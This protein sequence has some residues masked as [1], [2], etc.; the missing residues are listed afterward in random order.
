MCL[1]TCWG[2]SANTMPLPSVTALNNGEYQFPLHSAAEASRVKWGKFSVIKKYIPNIIAFS[3]VGESV[4]IIELQDRFIFFSVRHIIWSALPPFVR[5]L[6]GF[7]R[8]CSQVIISINL[9]LT[10]EQSLATLEP[11]S[12]PAGH[13]TN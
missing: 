2:L 1:S 7:L 10:K 3:E 13:Y 6:C 8:L 5:E 9:T 4:W 12:L 11:T